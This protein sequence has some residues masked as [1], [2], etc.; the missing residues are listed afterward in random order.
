[1]DNRTCSDVDRTRVRRRQVSRRRR[2]LFARLRAT[3]LPDA[4]A[5]GAL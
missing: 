3:P 4:T 2:R 1:M 5:I